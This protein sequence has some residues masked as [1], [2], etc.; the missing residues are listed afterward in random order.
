MTTRR[1]TYA[2]SSV[3]VTGAVF[4]YL[5]SHVSP[6]A[7][8]ELVASADRGAVA[9]FAILSL[10]MSALRTWRYRLFLGASGIDAPSLPLF[11]IVLVRNLF[12]D[13]LPARIGSLAYV[14]LVRE[15]LGVPLAPA[16][17]SFALALVFD[18]LAQAPIL[19]LAILF[20][21]E[22]IAVSIPLLLTAGV[23]VGV[24]SGA[25]LLLL[26]AMI[27]IGER[28]AL[29]WRGRHGA[30]VAAFVGRLRRDV[31][32]TARAG[33]YGRALVLS[34]LIRVTKYAAL[35][36][37]LY[38]LLAPRGYGLAD[39]GVAKVLLGTMAAEAA[40]SLPISGIAGFGAYEGTWA[41]V[42]QLLGYPADL[43]KLTSIAHHLFTQVWGYGLGGIALLALLLPVFGRKEETPAPVRPAAWPIFAAEVFGLVLLLVASLALAREL[44][45][46]PGAE[47]QPAASSASPP[48]AAR[49]S[50]ARLARRFPE[51]IVFDSNRGGTFGIHSIAS[52]GTDV[53]PIV[54][55]PAHETYP[56]PSPDGRWI[57]F[58]RA[59]STWR[60]APSDVWIARADGGDARELAADGT[61]PTFSADGET[62]YFERGR[63]E[64]WSV[65]RGG[66]APKRLFDPARFGFEGREL[67][68][69]RVSPDGAFVYLTVDRPRR[70]HAWGF[71]LRGGTAFEVGPGCEPA[72]T[73]DPRYVVWIRERGARGGSGVHLLDRENGS[74]AELADADG[75]IGTEYFPT[76]TSDR[77]FLLYAAAPERERSHVDGEFSLFVKDLGN[78]EVFRLTFDRHVN[79]WPKRLPGS[80]LREG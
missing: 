48:E 59:A 19:L 38:A 20:V 15:R 27:G 79:R 41:A 12:V 35:Y 54:D 36:V 2:A 5:L 78:A 33:I 45:A 64:V 37:F 51:R 68:K 77:R 4:S 73:T 24:V 10:A 30:P 71:D 26:P 65:P 25:A 8:I 50:L 46:A 28:L 9:M 34:L 58:A 18:V 61:F 22:G 75:P 56:D 32:T 43:A 67:V 72:P 47:P 66:G 63:R 80:T 16:T 13:L 52:D 76:V 31:E 23:V 53:R 29:R 49:P 21:G 40:A 14:Y 6:G 55:G 39:L 44:F 17:A 69:P 57:V 3:L 11:L 62:V 60:L 74:T 42:F 7:V 70:W 1:L